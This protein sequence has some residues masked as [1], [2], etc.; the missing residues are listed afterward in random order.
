QF[1]NSSPYDMIQKLK[2]MF[3]KQVGVESDFVRNHN[4]HN[5]GKTIGELHALI[6][7]YDTGLPKKAATPQVLAIQGGRMQKSNKKS[8]NAKR[9]VKEKDDACHHCKEV[10]H[11]KRNYLMYLAELM[12]K[13]KHTGSAS[14]SAIFT[15]E[16]FS[17]L[18]KSWVERSKPYLDSTCLW[19]YRFA[20][21]KDIYAVVDNC[22]TAQEIWL[23]V[24]Q[25]MKGSSIGDQEK[26][27]RCVC[28]EQLR[29]LLPKLIFSFPGEFRTPPGIPPNL[30][31]GNATL[32]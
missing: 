19:H 10:R 26:K 4:I 23:R 15:I 25:I 1:E 3:E 27:A 17:F 30:D 14:T 22:E 16:L 18:N 7:K 21:I 20:H 29:I 5:I 31:D 13:K 6:I 12:K 24:K 2:S 8:Q 32:I 11:W 28:C 9:K